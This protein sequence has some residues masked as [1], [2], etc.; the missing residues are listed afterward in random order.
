MRKSWWF[1]AG[2]VAGLLVWNA[3]VVAQTD[4]LDRIDAIYTLSERD[5]TAALEQMRALGDELGNTTPYPVLRDYLSKRILLELTLPRLLS[6][7]CGSWPRPSTTIP[8]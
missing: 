5:N 1:I 6:P 2:I 4:Q 7:V 8:A 3:P